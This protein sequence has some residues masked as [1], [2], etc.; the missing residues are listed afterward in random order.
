VKNINFAF[1][2]WFN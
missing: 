2:R 1:L